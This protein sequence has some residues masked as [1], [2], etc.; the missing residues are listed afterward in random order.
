MQE[1]T[2]MPDAGRRRPHGKVL[3]ETGGREAGG[4]CGARGAKCS[5]TKARGG[6]AK[7]DRL[8]RWIGRKFWYGRRTGWAMR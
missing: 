1:K 8:S 4:R 7:R 5:R 6:G 2:G 3:L